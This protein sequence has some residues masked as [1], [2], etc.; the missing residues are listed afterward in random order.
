[1]SNSVAKVKLRELDRSDL[2]RLNGWRNDKEIIELLGNNF[3]FISGAIDENWF[4]SYLQD[5]ERNVRLAIIAEETGE[6]VGNVN[7]TSIHRVNRSAEYSI[8]IGEKRYWSKGIGVEATRLML[9]HAFMDLNLNRVYLT[10][11]RENVRALRLYRRLNF[12]EE[13]CQRQSIF[14][15]G[16]YRDLIAMSI[17]KREFLRMK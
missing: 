12:V 8:L 3:L 4:Q 1:M 2:P 17:L 10:V 16:S 11:I 9:Y 13:G 15:D 14:K 5:R 6:Y 7:L